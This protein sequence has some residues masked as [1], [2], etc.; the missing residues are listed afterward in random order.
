MFRSIL[1]VAVL[2]GVIAGLAATVLHGFKLSPLIA[3]A[4]RYEQ[5]VA[6]PG[7]NSA[8]SPP[9]IDMTADDIARLA[10]TTAVNLLTGIGFGLLLNGFAALGMAIGQAETL[11]V[12]RGVLWGVA[13]YVCFS[14]AP[15]LGMPPELPGMAAASLV[16]RQIWWVVTVGST[17]LSLALLIFA[18]RVPMKT[19]GVA[20]LIAPHVIGAPHTTG[21]SAVPAELAASFAAASLVTAALFWLVLG[22]ASGWLH[23]RLI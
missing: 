18:R 7:Q 8:E 1:V 14:L 12:G 15:A 13:G 19:L 17:A 16:A 5:G 11:S 23:R 20:L 21:G 9:A 4:E 10:L 22:A 6:V 3:V 2:A